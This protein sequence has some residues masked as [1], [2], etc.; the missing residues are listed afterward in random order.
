MATTAARR[1]TLL[2][3]GAAAAAVA[4]ACI[5]T[6]GA[7]PAPGPLP[8][9]EAGVPAPAAPTGGEPSVRVGLRTGLARVAFGGAAGVRVVEPDGALLL[10]LPAGVTGEAA[11]EQGRLVLRSGSLRA[12]TDQAT[13]VPDAPGGTVRIDGREYRGEV[14]L[15]RDR[16]GVTAVNLLGLEQYLAGVVNAEMGTRAPG[17]QAALEAQAII[18]RT[19]ALRNLGRWRSLGFDLQ[20]SVADQAYAGAASET[21]AGRAAV[22]ATRG[23]VLEHDGELV[24]AFFFSTCGG[25]TAEGTEVF[26]GARRPYLRSIDDRA[27]DG[28]AW[29]RISP[30]FRWEERWTGA[31]LLATLRAQLPGIAQL[32]PSAVDRVRDLRIARTGTSGRAAALAIELGRQTVTVDAPQIRGVLRPRPQELLRS[33][34]FDLEVRRAGGQVT[35][36]VA[37][38]GGAG[39]GVGF[40]Q[41]GAVGRARAG[42][43]APTILAAYYPGTTLVRRY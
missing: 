11:L 24:D 36:L 8:P 31:E 12:A 21:A 17:E 10:R 28:T 42:Q 38:G 25:R 26:R 32:P 40:C 5:R 33:N 7:V 15:L 23:V 29:C 6:D 41:W 1:A 19:Y 18:S 9:A 14:A 16:A 30:R 20:S 2:S 22:A 43:D 34:A 39:H 35:E 27:P 3:A 37:R 13:L 4:A